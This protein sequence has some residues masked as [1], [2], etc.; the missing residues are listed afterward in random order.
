MN[1]VN[2][3][4]EFVFPSEWK[5]SYSPTAKIIKLYGVQIIDIGLEEITFEGVVFDKI[6]DA[7]YI[8]MIV[9]NDDLNST[10]CEEIIDF[11]VIS[12][13]CIHFKLNRLVQPDIY[14]FSLL[15]WA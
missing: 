13:T 8:G 4:T 14:D 6:S 5:F 9:I 7:K 12:D 2:K 15:L 10:I 11:K 3:Q 1:S